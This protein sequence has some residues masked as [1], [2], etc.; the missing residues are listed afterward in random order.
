MRTTP[1]GHLI[2]QGINQSLK[3]VDKKLQQIHSFKPLEEITS[4]KNF[5]EESEFYL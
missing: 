1:S 4:D 5:M 2:A 3:I